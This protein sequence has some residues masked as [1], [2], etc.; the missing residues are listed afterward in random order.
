MKTPDEI[1]A[2]LA[3]LQ[4][5]LDRGHGTKTARMLWSMSVDTLEWALNERPT[6]EGGLMWELDQTA[7]TQPVTLRWQQTLNTEALSI[8]TA[9]DYEVRGVGRAYGGGIRRDWEVRHQGQRIGS[10]SRL[11]EAKRDA[12]HHADRHAEVPAAKTA[13]NK[14]TPLP[15]VTGGR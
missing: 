13:S 2:R 14:Y 3:V 15:R 8:W 6:F 5:M 7:R 4:G 9:G 12:Q 11:S 10:P 1:R